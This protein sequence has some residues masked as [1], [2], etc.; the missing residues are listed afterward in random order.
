[1]TT[2]KDIYK[3]YLVIKPWGD[4][5]TIFN[6]KDKLGITLDKI[7]PG[8]STS[9]HWQKKKKTG[10]IILKGN[11]IIQVGIHSKNNWVSKPLSILVIRPGLF[12]SL[13]NPKKSKYP[14]YALE[15]ETPF[16]K[17]DLLRFKDKYGRQKKGYENKKYMKKLDNDFIIFKKTSLKNSYKL[18]DRNIII[19][20][21]KKR[22]QLNKLKNN[23]VSAI[24][25]GKI[26]DKNQK[27]ALN[28]GEII[29][30]NTL[31]ILT[32]K[33]SIHTKLL[34]LNVS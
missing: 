18:F 17:K 25:E 20:N 27:V 14:I 24:L 1:M 30:T 8:K 12:H 19:Q 4:E 13:K 11:P 29:K 32:K 34:V 16:I 28:Y 31:K 6:D 21:I 3:N 26:I 33:F 9:L 15:F 23:S 2:K 22:S 7:N 10:F 5:Y